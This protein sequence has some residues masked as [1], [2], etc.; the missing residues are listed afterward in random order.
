MG[1]SA[2]TMQLQLRV[3]PEEKSTIQRAAKR[4]GLDMSAYVLSRVLPSYE[5]RVHDL[6]RLLKDDGQSRFVLAELNDL[7]SGLEADDLRQAVSM[8][9][10]SSLSPKM[11]NYWAAMVEQACADQDIPLPVWTR[12]IAPLETPMFGSSLESLR[13]HL[14]AH[15]P[16]AFKR[17]NIFIDT[18]LGGRV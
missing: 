13:L 14:L 16:P 18:T 1:Q 2:K 3:S 17:R 5:R 15:S 12:T 6:V 9:P 10:P 4:A 7:L 8:S 11:A